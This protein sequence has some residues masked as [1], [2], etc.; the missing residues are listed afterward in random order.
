MGRKGTRVVASESMW[1]EPLKWDKRAAAAG[2]RHRVFC[3]SL[4]D[5]FEDGQGQM[6]TSNG[7][8]AAINRLA[9]IFTGYYGATSLVATTRERW[10]MPVHAFSI[11]LTQRPISIGYC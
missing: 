9:G 1:K 2:E 10:P 11:S 4:A 6:K 5:M 8:W 7:Q 3:A